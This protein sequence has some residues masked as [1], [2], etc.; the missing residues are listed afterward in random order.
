MYLGEVVSELSTA[1]NCLVTFKPHLDE[2]PQLQLS[3]L[4]QLLSYKLL[5]YDQALSTTT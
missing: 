3:V 2:R 5:M 1:T 4:G